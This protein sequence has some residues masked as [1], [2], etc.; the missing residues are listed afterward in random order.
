MDATSAVDAI[1]VTSRETIS[2]I[3]VI[4][5]AFT[6]SVPIGA[7]ASAALSAAA[8]PDAEMATPP[9]TAAPSATTIRVPSFIWRGVVVCGT[10]GYIIKSPPDM[11]IDV[12]VM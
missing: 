9:M 5:I 6:H 10:A 7:M 12:P 1:P 3:T 4:R 2:G 8:L 11:S